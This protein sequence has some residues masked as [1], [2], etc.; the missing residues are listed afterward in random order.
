MPSPGDYSIFVRN[1]ENRMVLTNKN[2]PLSLIATGSVDAVD[3]GRSAITPLVWAS[4]GSYLAIDNPILVFHK[5]TNVRVSY[6]ER[7][8]QN[9]YVRFRVQYEGKSGGVIKYF[10]LGNGPSKILSDNEYGIIVNEASGEASFDSRALYY[11]C[12]FFSLFG[13]RYLGKD[14]ARYEY[15]NYTYE[16]NATLMGAVILNGWLVPTQTWYSSGPGW[17]TCTFGGHVLRFRANEADFEFHTKVAAYVGMS[18]AQIPDPFISTEDG[19]M[20]V[21]IVSGFVD[22]FDFP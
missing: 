9:G 5:D 2:T 15:G 6:C 20:T 1:G 18:G 3:A 10:V 16:G 22:P 21:M 7:R 4:L 14:A 19:Y 12:N 13:C 17:L 8:T 11:N